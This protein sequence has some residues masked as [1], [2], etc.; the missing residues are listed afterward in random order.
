MEIETAIEAKKQSVACKIEDL[1]S[2]IPK[3]VAIRHN[4]RNLCF[5]STTQITNNENQRDCLNVNY[6]KTSNLH[7]ESLFTTIS[8]LAEL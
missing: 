7:M 1:F 4:H 2:I 5:E 3:S 8:L 6:L